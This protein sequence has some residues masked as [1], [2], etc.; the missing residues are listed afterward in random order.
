MTNRYLYASGQD[1]EGFEEYHHKL[2]RR[3]KTKKVKHKP[4]DYGSH[5][6]P[7][8]MFKS[9][10]NASCHLVLQVLHM[11][12]LESLYVRPYAS[13]ELANH[14]RSHLPAQEMRH[15]DEVCAR[16]I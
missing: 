10:S 3:G 5:E 12:A 13:D 2:Q 15:Q 16:A 6:Y 4:C 11:V 1:A 8:D 9:H 7:Y 14:L